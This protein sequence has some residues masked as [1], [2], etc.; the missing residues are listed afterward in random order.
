MLA[1]ALGLGL[2]LALAGGAWAGESSETCL[3]CHSSRDLTGSSGNSLHVDGQVLAGSAHA[4]LECVDCHRDARAIPHESRLAKVRCVSCHARTAESLAASAHAAV[5]GGG[6]RACA[7]C[8]AGRNPHD[9]R[10]AARISGEGCAGC[11]ARESAEFRTSVHG[12]ARANGHDDAAACW[13]CHGAPHAALSH[14]D[15]TSPTHRTRLAETCGKCH[16]DRELMTRRKIA[17]PEAVALYE[18]SVH[19]RSSHPE[20]ATCNDC[21]ES[22]RLK[23]NTDPT[24]SIHRL[25]IS[26]TCSRCHAAQAQGYDRG[27]HGTAL[28]RGVLA[29]PTC[30][31]CHGE[32]LIRGPGDKNS[33]VM[34]SSVTK[35]CAHC[36]EAEGI[37]ETYGLPAG[38]LGTYQDSFHGLAARGGSPAVANC[39][40]CHGEHEVLPSSDPRSAV[41]PARL[42]QTCGKCHPGAGEKFALGPVHVAETS[43]SDPLIHGIRWVYLLLIAGTIG[44]MLAH[45]GLD[46]V[47]KMR[48]HMKRH[49]GLLEEHAHEA[50]ASLG[51]WFVRMTAFERVQHVLLATSFFT[52]VYTGFALKFPESW[53]FAWLAR[54]EHGYA[55]R[56]WSHRIA[57]IVMV[58]AA[59]AHVVYAFTARGR[60]TIGALLPH[61][62]DLGQVW[63]NLMY[64]LG[65]R[66]D[67]PAFQRFGYIEKAE[68]WALIW[69]TFVMTATGFALWFENESLRF[70]SKRM[71]DVAT[72]VHYYEAWLAFL[73][74][75]VWHVYQNVI[76]PDVYPMNWT[77][78]TGR[79][80][81][82]QLR[83]EHRGE[84]EALALAESAAIEAAATEAPRAATTA[85]PAAAS[86]ATPVAA[87]AATSGTVSAATSGTPAAGGTEEG[88]SGPS[89]P[90]DL[91]DPE[92]T[93]A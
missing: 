43:S 13:S 20:A 81:E 21:H 76:N 1:L 14:R 70:T 48:R 19:G 78:L 17:I 5:G 82:P 56:S 93:P 55:L 22:H 8:H 2:G 9:V 47:S 85:T 90:G 32:H 25:N 4:K 38:R 89:A 24:S 31:D 50:E 66:R 87:P 10:R 67:P 46:Y 60:S 37:R 51:R 36:H 16:A 64:M 74:I 80:S 83:H 42:P 12:V 77:W 40:S 35:T 7:G 34:A 27:V 53:P 44:G 65:R 45:N 92:G 23:T 15:P 58:V 91:P 6:D 26:K 72:L 84:W 79:I 61:P 41:H 3:T 75:L 28:A 62:R 88:S 69:G 86:T 54:M 57:A 63:E 52:L 30:T 11:H 68:Y 33:P 18:K 29:A 49:L 73:A 71:L 39:A 59:L